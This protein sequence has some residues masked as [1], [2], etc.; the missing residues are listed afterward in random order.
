MDRKVYRAGRNK[1]S[2]P[3]YG[4]APCGHC[5]SVYV[6]WISTNKVILVRVKK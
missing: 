5:S 4:D 2:Y 6:T 1:G 3:A